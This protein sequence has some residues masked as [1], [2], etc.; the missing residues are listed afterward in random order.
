M[1]CWM[2]GKSRQDKIRNDTIR[3]SVGVASIVEKLVE[4]RH[5]CFGHV[6]RRSAN[7]LENRHR[8]FGHVKRV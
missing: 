1:L 3:E 8:C 6:E 7:Y 5:R 2:S 4:N